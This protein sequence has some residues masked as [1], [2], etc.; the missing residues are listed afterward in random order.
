MEVPFEN[1]HTLRKEDGI[2]GFM[3]PTESEHDPFG[4]GH[5]STSLS[6]ALGFAFSDRIYN[7]EA[8]TVAVVGDGAF[9]GGMISEALNNLDPSLPFI[10]VFNENEMSISKNVGTFARYIS[11]I[12]SHRR[13]FAVKNRARTLLSESSI[14]IKIANG[15]RR[16]K[17]KLKNIAR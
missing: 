12:R 13:Y 17:R 1:F 11:N 10:I 9:T 15:L 4:S 14:G 5:S 3:K 2:S 6:A 7:K 8:F 16:L